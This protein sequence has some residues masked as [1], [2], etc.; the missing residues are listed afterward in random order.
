[1]V[2]QIL[3]LATQ[4]ETPARDMGVATSTVSFF[5]A[6]GSSVGVATFGAL[7]TNRLT[8]RLTGFDVSSLTPE[9]IARLG[10][11][12][13]LRVTDAFANS[14]TEVFL[15][16][17]PALLVG[18][19]L[20]FLLREHRLRSSARPAAAPDGAIDGHLDGA[21]IEVDEALPL[22]VGH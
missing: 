20:T 11:I 2:M 17:V 6:V 10:P 18:F 9:R 16:C 3:V 22:A 8:G 19:A 21:V 1:M 15:Y 12:D 4:N 7:Y 5:R 13:R 14:I